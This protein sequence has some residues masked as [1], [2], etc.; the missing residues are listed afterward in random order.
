MFEWAYS[1]V[2]ASLPGNGG[3][4]CASFLSLS[5]RI[6]ET[7][8]TLAF[9]VIC[10]LW[11][12]RNLSL[13]PQIC[14]CGQKND[15]G[16]RVLL[17]VI[18]LMW[19]MEI[20][21]KF[22]SRTVIYLF[23]PCHITT[24]LQAN[25]P[26]EKSIYWIQHSMMVIVPYYLLQ[27]GGAYNVERYSDFSWC[28]V[29]YGMNLLYHFVILQAVAIP[30]QVNL[31]LML[32]PMELDPFYGPYYR[33]IAVAHQAILCPLTCKVFCAVSSLFATPKQCLCD[34]SCECN[35]EQCCNQKRLL[36]KD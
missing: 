30:L 32:C 16:K 17:V 21:F 27:L 25:F 29:A 18:S 1:G 20:G 10:I 35:L 15:T 4:E 6:T 23:N 5:R 8:I 11:G 19:G 24:A 34:P 13:I 3:P 31:N 2:N 7:G 33:I 36:H 12:Y 28:L 22:A 14:S 26:F 9:A